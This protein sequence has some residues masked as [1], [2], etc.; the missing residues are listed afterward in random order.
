MGDLSIFTAVVSV[1]AI[2]L[3]V[4]VAL[5]DA[6]KSKAAKEAARS[7]MAGLVGLSVWVR[8]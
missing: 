4:S 6:A 3:V 1:W 2:L 5:N 8:K 7:F